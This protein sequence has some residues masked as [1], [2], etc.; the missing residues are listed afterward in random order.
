MLRKLGM[1]TAAG[2]MAISFG[3]GHSTHTFADP[4]NGNNCVGS[5]VSTAAQNLGG[6]GDFFHDQ[7][8]NPGKQ[9]QAFATAACGKHA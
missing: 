7:G 1:L 3:L 6:L 5:A 9:I 2:A 8:L 4:G